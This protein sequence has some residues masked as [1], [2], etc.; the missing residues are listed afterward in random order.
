MHTPT[1]VYPCDRT[2]IRTEQAAIPGTL[3]RRRQDRAV[4]YTH[5]RTCIHSSLPCMR[6]SSIHVPS[7]HSSS[8]HMLLSSTRVTHTNTHRTEGA[9]ALWSGVTPT[10][11]R[12]GTQQAT[13]FYFK[14]LIDAKVCVCL[15]VCVPV[16][17]VMRRQYGG[18]G[19]GRKGTNDASCFVRSLDAP[20]HHLPAQHQHHQRLDQ[21]Y[22]HHHLS[23]TSTKGVGQ[24]RP[25]PAQEAGGV[26][27]HDLR[28]PRLLPRHVSLRVRVNARWGSVSVGTGDN[29]WWVS[30][31]RHAH[32]QAH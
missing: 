29:K 14:S 23:H 2:R 28:P 17:V 19:K 15:C 6:A 3:G 8:P 24:G 7:K 1:T 13:M 32:A 4:R 9:A 11:A 27:V 12:N 10:I 20:H 31:S 21:P 5:M 22:H 30:P 26:A 18:M 16:C 25:R